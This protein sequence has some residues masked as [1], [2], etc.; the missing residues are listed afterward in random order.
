MRF[1]AN[2][3]YAT[4]TNT[5]FANTWYVVAF[6]DKQSR[7]EYV[8]KAQGMAVKAI[9]KAEISH[10][11]PAPKHFSGAKRAIGKAFPEWPGMI[12]EVYVCHPN[13]AN[14]LRDL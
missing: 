5:G 2:N 12:G 6:A 9:T 8:S 3:H 14:Y 10:Y 7:D 11:V 4:D 1:A 13:D